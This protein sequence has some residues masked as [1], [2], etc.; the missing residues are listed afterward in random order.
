MC[1]DSTKLCG[2]PGVLFHMHAP[3]VQIGSKV[4]ITPSDCSTVNAKRCLHVQAV[5]SDGK[6]YLMVLLVSRPPLLLLLQR[7]TPK[8][9]VSQVVV[10]RE[11]PTR[12]CDTS[13]TTKSKHLIT[14]HAPAHT[15][16]DKCDIC[17]LLRVSGMLYL[18]VRM[19]GTYIQAVFLTMVHCKCYATHTDMSRIID[20]R[21]T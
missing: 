18:L 13:T 17:L 16:N 20:R 3:K 12:C 6:Y 7:T 2:I 9:L 8:P 19:C 21:A 15:K 10:C 4:A 11:G 5:Q 14:V 1:G